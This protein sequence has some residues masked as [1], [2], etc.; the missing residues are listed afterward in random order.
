MRGLNNR[1]YVVHTTPSETVKTFRERYEANYGFKQDG[2][3]APLNRSCLG[4]A[5]PPACTSVFCFGGG[6]MCPVPLFGAP[7]VR[8]AWLPWRD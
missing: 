3:R 2:V 5:W 4:S 6:G 8:S 7:P 1:L